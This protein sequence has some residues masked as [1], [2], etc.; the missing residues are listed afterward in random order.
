[1]NDDARPAPAARHTIVIVDDDER[2]RKHLT[3]LLDWSGEWLVVGEAS[4]V[5][6]AIVLCRDV[7]PDLV[8]L[9]R[10]MADGDGLELARLFRTLARRPHVVLLTG[11]IVDAAV[12][13]RAAAAGIDRCIEKTTPPL[14]L[15][16][17]LRELAQKGTA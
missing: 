2:V 10:Y 9:D 8:L 12:E 11:G 13:A 4:E 15:L 3:L 6:E 5:H 17:S 7:R 16:R 14:E 1:M